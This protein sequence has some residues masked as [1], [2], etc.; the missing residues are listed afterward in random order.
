MRR[1]AKY[2]REVQHMID[3]AEKK[4]VRYEV[5]EGRDYDDYSWVFRVGPGKVKS[6]FHLK[7]RRWFSVSWGEADPSSVD[8]VKS[9]IDRKAK[10]AC[11]KCG[12][13]RRAAPEDTLQDAFDT[14]NVPQFTGN[15]ASLLSDSKVRAVLES[16]LADGSVKDDT[17]NYSFSGSMPAGG[18]IP[19]QNE[20]GF[21]ESVKNLLTDAYGT[22]ASFLQGQANVGPDPIVTYGGKFV[23]DGHHRWSQVF[24]ANP[25]ASLPSLD[26][27]P[28]SGYSPVDVLKA[29]HTAI[30][31]D[32]GKVPQSS[33]SGMNVLSGIS[34]AEVEG[35]VQDYLRADVMD[36]WRA[37]TDIRTERELTEHLHENLTAI[38]KRGTAK[39]A[40]PR[41]HMPQTDSGGD[42]AD[43][44]EMLEKGLINIEPP[45]EKASRRLRCKCCGRKL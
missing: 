37:H 42:T 20:I 16:G 14:S 24:V 7:G 3:Y 17:L 19:S 6:T 15:L 12:R 35:A 9:A 32:L 39:G 34:L 43:R 27:A 4:G 31:A 2:P 22:L 1:A 40:P 23:I 25:N 18:L 28:K 5:S 41:D 30:G 38:A 33:A 13:R 45:Y 21:D 11:Q 10:E 26:I 8:A 44:L 29:V 36:T